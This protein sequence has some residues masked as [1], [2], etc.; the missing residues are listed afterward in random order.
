MKKNGFY[1]QIIQE[2]PFGYALHEI[3]CGDD[4][5]PSDYR[6]LLVNPAFERI[7]GLKADMVI[8]RT[9]LEVLPGT[10]HYWIET[11]GKVALT[12]E[13][14]S[15]QNYSGRLGKHFE[16]SAFSPVKGQFACIFQDITERKLSEI[17]LHESEQRYAFLAQSANELSCTTSIKDIFA[18]TAKKINQLLDG[19]SIVSIVEF[20][21]V[22]NRWKMQHIEGVEK[23]IK[24]LSKVFGQDISKLEGDIS[25]KYYKK[26]FSGRLTEVPLDIPGLFNNK[27][28]NF[29][30]KAIHKLLSIDKMY[31]IAFK[32]HKQLLGNITMITQNKTTPQKTDLIEAFVKLVS[33]FTNR[34]KIE[35]AIQKGNQRLESFLEISQKMTSTLE[36]KK[37]MQMI[38]DNAIKIPG[39]ESG[40]IYLQH[41]EESIRLAATSPALPDD[42]PEHFRVAILKDHPHIE[43]TFRTGKPVLMADALSAKLTP[44]EQEIINLR[45]LRSNHYMPIWVREKTIGVLILSSID[46]IHILTDEEI[47]MLHGFANQAAHIIENIHH[48]ETWKQHAR[49]LAKEVNE[50]KRMERDLIK[51][52]EKAEEANRLKTAFLQ[53]M[54]HEIRTPLNSIIGFSELINNPDI[55]EGRRKHFTDII[56]ERGWQLTAII[57]DIIT[58]SSLETGQ[59]RLRSD[60]IHIN[61]LIVDQIS[62]FTRQANSK[63]ILLTAEQLLPE[64]EALVY[65]DKT[66]LVQILNNLITNALK[67][68]EEG[69]VVVGCQKQDN[70]LRFYVRDTGIGIDQSK[71]TMI[72]ER[73]TQADDTISRDFGGTGLGLSICKGFVELMSGAIWVESEPG[74]GATFQ[75]TIPYKAV[76]GNAENIP[77]IPEISAAEKEKSITLLVA[78]D[79]AANFAYLEALLETLFDTI[80]IQ[81][82]HAD[83]GQEA[84]DICREQQID[85]VLMDIKM[86]VMDGYTATKQIKSLKPHLPVI[87][88]T[89][90]ALKSE[91]HQ[92][93]DVFDDY[94]TKPFNM[95]KLRH[96]FRKYF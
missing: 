37:V 67:F 44:A 40:A 81:L 1:Q 65:T 94:I 70:K 35:E 31:C 68:T 5:M 13:P 58:I 93:G 90:Y 20:N 91:M 76:K 85:L 42:F 30:E 50:R 28:S 2:A 10:E 8:D 38:V 7:I 4:G 36:Q 17:A 87:A 43:R 25:T 34:L 32:Q 24:K 52:K 39:L 95:E 23:N 96:V 63:G 12:G 16:V 9:V 83:N 57:D 78:E 56:I 51:A 86:P 72:F 45:K 89:A 84:I 3:I 11:Y 33:N 15:F 64:E 6:F 61:E 54:S 88:Q 62:T 60:N 92:Y 21:N 66:K 74:K 77:S 22:T 27:F 71:A 48:Y 47:H 82:I 73:F 49:D 69:K 29:I 19:H 80:V 46:K 75:F 53:N 59:E 26:I 79:E 55:D 14:V 18:Y 41:P